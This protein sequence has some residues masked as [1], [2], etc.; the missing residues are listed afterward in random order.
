VA[1]ATGPALAAAVS[2]DTHRISRGSPFSPFAQCA[3]V[4]PGFSRGFAQETHLAVNP[5]NP[6]NILVSWIQDGRATDTVMASRDGGRSFSRVLVPGLS[7]CTGGAFDVASDP[8]VDFTADGRMAYFSAIVVDNPADPA[9]ASTAMFASRSFD[10]GFSWEVPS[11]VQPATGQFWDLPRLTAHPRR[12]KVAY[13][14]YDLREPPDLLHGFAL[15]SKTTDRGRSWSEPRVLYDPQTDDSWPGITKIL[16]NDDGSLLAV[17]TIVANDLR[18]FNSPKPTQQLG[19]RS[20]DGGRTWSRPITIG[21][22]S[23]RQVRDPATGNVLNTFDVFASQTVAPNGDVYV[24][25]LQPGPTNESSR[26]AVAR[27]TDGGRSWRQ[28]GFKVRGQG[29]LPTVEVAGDGTL[30]VLYYRIAP[31]SRDGYWPARITLA[32]STDR[33]R[34]WSQRSAAKKFNLLTTGSNARP[35]CFVGDYEGIG[36]LKHGVV[37]AFPMGKPV[38]KHKVDAYFIRVKT[39]GRDARRDR[40]DR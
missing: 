14:V 39:S 35:C 8:G 12:P 9:R 11:V 7:A 31:E 10:G 4:N 23:G 16:V 36:R 17:S 18:D 6:R 34:D 20:V 15:F 29:A 2:V 5:R 32:T 27:S 28:R 38:A 40:R 19:L 1:L 26:I 13:Y 37:A 21:N 33:G 24:S 30:A 3:Q 22:S 25:W